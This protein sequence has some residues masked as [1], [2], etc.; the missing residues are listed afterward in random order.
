MGY[1]DTRHKHG[2]GRPVFSPASDPP[3]PP[4]VSGVRQ[5]RHAV[6][7]AAPP[8]L[9]LGE[10]RGRPQEEVLPPQPGEGG[11]PDPG[12]ETLQTPRGGHAEAERPGWAILGSGTFSLKCYLPLCKATAV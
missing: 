9:C 2:S 6:L 5:D 8:P 1:G 7:N 4:A 10:E 12:D 11:A 3:S